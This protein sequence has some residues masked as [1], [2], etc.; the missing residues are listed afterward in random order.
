M[1]LEEVELSKFKRTPDP[2]GWTKTQPF[3]MA[4]CYFPDRPGI[5]V[6]GMS[7]EVEEYLKQFHTILYLRTLFCEG[8]GRSGY[9]NMRRDGQ[10][11]YVR[12]QGRSQAYRELCGKYVN[13]F[14]K[15]N[16]YSYVFTD[17]T[18]HTYLILR[19]MPT[20][21]SKIFH[22]PFLSMPRSKCKA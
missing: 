17:Y 2:K 1:K 11:I 5:V 20:D 6:K 15:P 19:R 13:S 9:W 21:R 7:E 22:I 10:P 8:K 18:N 4:F 3:V 12:R 14:E 16:R